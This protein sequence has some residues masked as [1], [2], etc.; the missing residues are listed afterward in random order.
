[1][2]VVSLFSGCGGLDLGFKQ[3]GFDFLWANEFDS[4]ISNPKMSR[5][6]MNFVPSHR[7]ALLANFAA[8]LPENRDRKNQMSRKKMLLLMHDFDRK[9]S[10]YGTE[11][12]DENKIKTP[13]R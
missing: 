11:R 3:A 6:P 1:M 7:R 2:K 13:Q 5:M 9:P 8:F 12:R 10:R 4:K